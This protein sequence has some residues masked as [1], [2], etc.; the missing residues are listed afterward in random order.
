VSRISVHPALLLLLLLTVVAAVYAPAL[1]GGYIFDDSLIVQNS[2]VVTEL[3]PLSEYFTRPFFTSALIESYDYYRPL[4][5]LSF[6]LDYRLHDG[7]ASGLHL[8]NLVLHLVNTALLVAWLRQRGSGSLSAMAL[9]ALW[10]LHPRV[11][12]D[13]AKEGECLCPYCGTRYVYR[14][15]PVKGH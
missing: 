1:G 13:V 11:F 14:G 10:A 5:V 8:T 9:A 6:A 7:A 15:A 2:P 12:L 3:R 4:V